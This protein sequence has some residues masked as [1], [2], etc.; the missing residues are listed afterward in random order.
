MTLNH[1]RQ[2]G[3][4]HWSPYSRFDHITTDLENGGS[5]AN[6]PTAYGL[7]ALSVGST[8]STTWGTPFGSVRPTLLVELHRET[9]SS[10]GVGS[11]DSQTQGVVGFGMTTRI[12]RGVFAFAESR[13]E[14]NLSATLDRQAM[15]GVRMAF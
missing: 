4:M 1:P 10:A 3:G 6:F 11:T 8:A 2:T 13:Y 15:L 9:V 5:P 12:S 14:S 7:S